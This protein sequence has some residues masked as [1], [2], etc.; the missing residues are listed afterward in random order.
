MEKMDYTL[1]A[2]VE[3]SP[4]FPL[5]KVLSILH[6]VSLGVWYLHCRDPPFIH[7]DL[8]PNN[9][10]VNTTS[11]V[12][13]ISDFAVM[14][15]VS[16]YSHDRDDM[17]KVPGTPDFMAPEAVSQRP[18]YG[19]PLDV[20]S[21]GGVA[22]FTIAGE[23]PSPTDREV[24]DPKTD[25]WVIVSEVER[26]KK[27]LNKIKGDVV[28]LRILVE[29]CLHNN[30]NMRPT[31]ENI[32]TRI[33]E[34]KEDYVRRHPDVENAAERNSQHFQEQLQQ[35][36]QQLSQK[37][38]QIHQKDQELHQRNQEIR[39]KTQ[40]VQQKDQ[41]IQQK[42]Q[43]I[44]QKDQEIFQLNQQMH[45]Q[46]FEKDQQIHQLQQSNRSLPQSLNQQSESTDWVIQRR[47][48]T[49]LEKTLG[50]GGWGAVTEAMF[51]GCKVAAKCLHNEIISPY[52]L[53]L[54]SRE[55]NMA[56]RCRHPNILQFIG[57][58]NQGLP[59]IVTE[60]MHTSLR[61]ILEQGQLNSNQIIPISLGVAYG[62]NYLHRNTPAILHRD[63]SS[64]NVLLNPLP[65]NQWLPKLSD[66]G[67]TN[68]VRASSTINAGNPTY[69]SPEANQGQ[70]STAMDVFSY[71]VLMFEMCSRE[72]PAAPPKQSHLHQ[73][74][75]G[76]TEN[77]LRNPI[78][79]CL[80]VDV[81]RRPDM[82]YVINELLRIRQ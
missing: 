57:A 43:Q 16:P 6:D 36:D 13:K 39:Q 81:Q 41:Q 9:V 30:P 68:F 15:V 49:I 58:T 48:I 29:E 20:F 74:R 79:S 73:V 55:M 33:K 12:A 62:L 40:D 70:H 37:D 67:S 66:F 44:Q 50:K 38:R 52:N 23:W 5:H 42:D 64:S 22:L 1:R 17:T 60:L 34:I 19:L 35:K 51:R 65:N 47:E 77:M 82:D 32:S 28:V 63:V 25:S 69:A 27:Y 56:A 71:G 11:L 24:I 53:G 14:R 3:R 54:F 18:S 7:R 45:R 72:L 61:K 8:T 75:W 10:F 31:M 26:R 4:S 2:L 80:A 59:I 21:Y 46:L 76:A 78:W